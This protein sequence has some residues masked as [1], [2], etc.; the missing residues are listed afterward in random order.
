MYAVQGTVIRSHYYSENGQEPIGEVSVTKY[1]TDPRDLD[2]N[3]E[4]RNG[5]VSVTTTQKFGTKGTPSYRTITD[6]KVILVEYEL[7]RMLKNNFD[8]F[9]AHNRKGR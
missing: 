4:D 1:S 7:L 9:L 2:G 6:K 3:V 5:L 8:W